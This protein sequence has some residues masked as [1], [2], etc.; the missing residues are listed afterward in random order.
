MEQI[1]QAERGQVGL[2][3]LSGG[4]GFVSYKKILVW[5]VFAKMCPSIP[6]ANILFEDQ[7]KEGMGST[8]SK[9]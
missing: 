5:S 6:D 7:K 1:A 3:C 9:K 2:L 4:D 8:A